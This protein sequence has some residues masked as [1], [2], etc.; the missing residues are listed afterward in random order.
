MKQTTLKESFTLVGKGLHTGVE[1]EAEFMPAPE[2]HGYK[3]RVS[4]LRIS[5]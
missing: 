4:T 5:L 2:N 3:I 1:I